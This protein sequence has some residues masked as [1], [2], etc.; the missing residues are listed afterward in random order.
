MLRGFYTAAAGMIAQQRKTDLLTNNMANSNTPGFK[1]DQS[2][3]R[4]F[5]ELLLQRMGKQTVPVD[6]SFTIPSS[7]LVGAV[8]TGV[9]MQEVLPKFLQG[10]LQE[11][12]NNTDLAL[13]D[14]NPNSTSSVFFSVQDKDGSVKYT[15]NG[16]FTLDG[17]GNLTTADGL[18]VLDSNGK[19]IRL[20]SVD[21]T[22]DSN[23][24]INQQGR[25]VATIGVAYAANTNSLVK[26]G[27]GLY[28]M[29]DNSALPQAPGTSF[30][31]KQGYLESSNVDTTQSMTDMLSAY[32]SFEANQK[33]LQAYDHSMD[34]AVNEVGRVNG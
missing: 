31:L 28:R 2:S 9:Y 7:S 32:R 34:K 21:F 10:D 13:Q 6:N 22:V 19:K 23:G 29:E 33:V 14:L 25:R 11:T 12:Q 24:Q 3:L 16:N 27:D 15:R 5:P 1:A 18:Y 26:E 20:D 30:Q 8:N 4:A 17:D